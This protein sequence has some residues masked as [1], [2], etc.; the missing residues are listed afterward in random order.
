M[1]LP[2]AVG[3]IAGER[4]A[5]RYWSAHRPALA[6]GQDYFPGW[7]HYPGVLVCG[8]GANFLTSVAGWDC[9]PP[10]QPNAEFA[11]A[12]PFDPN[13]HVTFTR[14]ALQGPVFADYID[15]W[16]IDPLAAPSWLGASPVP[17]GNHWRRPVTDA[18][19]Q[20]DLGRARAVDP[21]IAPPEVPF[22]EPYP[23]PYRML[24]LRPMTNPLRYPWREIGPEP[25][26]EGPVR[27]VTVFTP[28]RAYH[29][30]ERALP[31]RARGNTK[32]KK[33]RATLDGGSKLGLLVSGAS[34]LKDFLDCAHEALHD[35]RKPF[36]KKRGVST[37]AK[38]RK[39]F[40][41]TVMLQDLW[42]HS[43]YLGVDWF[44]ATT[45][46]M[47]KELLKDAVYGRVGRVGAMAIQ[48]NPYWTRPVGL[49]SGS[50]FW[51]TR[52]FNI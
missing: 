36:N 23:L 10:S 47:M 12:N 5:D 52:S 11:R 45:R 31:R 33:F 8:G 43:D 42:K 40:S 28:S 13:V 25:V 32:E 15:T 4:L 51:P 50:G 46:C 21:M 48:N 29:F 17:D 39:P 16:T 49:Q 7:H 3:L 18:E 37:E 41:R 1:P 6:P 9:S 26:E 14:V 24:N 44:R 34:E 30:R 2:L 27:D 20:R 19:R 22:P 35:V 38:Y